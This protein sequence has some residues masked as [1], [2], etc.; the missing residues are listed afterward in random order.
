MADSYR[1]SVMKAMT[2][3][4]EGT[5]VTPF[6]GITLPA[7]L[8][9]LVYR[10]RSRFGDNDP[11]TMLAL[12]EAPRPIGAQYAGDSEARN[13]TWLLLLQGWCPED[14]KHPSDPIYSLLDD[15][16]K[17]LDRITAISASGMPKYP[18]HYMLGGLISSFR[19]GQ[20]VVRPPTPDVSSKCF[21]YV[22]LQVG[23]ARIR[24]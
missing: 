10:G 14:K 17:R 9:D 5:T 6:T 20:P 2:V 16:E 4:L 1:L 3:L 11:P 13:E 8:N 15:T 7:N 23:L 24:T 19:V 12:L 22:P 18:E 21:F